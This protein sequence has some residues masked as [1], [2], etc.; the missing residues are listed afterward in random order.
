MPVSCPSLQ[1]DGSMR[2]QKGS[3]GSA[4]C[5]SVYG[6]H[7]LF[8]QAPSALSKPWMVADGAGQGMHKFEAAA[9]DPYGHLGAVPHGSK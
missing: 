2:A 5:S 3:R 9:V 4:A 7:K 8:G 1:S 6:K